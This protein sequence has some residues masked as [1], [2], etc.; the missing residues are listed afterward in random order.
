MKLEDYLNSSNEL[1]V[2][3]FNSPIKEKS[4][5]ILTNQK[6]ERLEIEYPL[7]P[8]SKILIDNCFARILSK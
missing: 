4:R 3:E 7:L 5:T 2:V 8:S 1:R 6:E